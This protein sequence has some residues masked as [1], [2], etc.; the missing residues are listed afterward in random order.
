MGKGG[1][2]G[3]MMWVVV[4]WG[5]ILERMLISPPFNLSKNADQHQS[6][7]K[8]PWTS[9]SWQTSSVSLSVP[10]GV[11]EPLGV[12][13]REKRNPAVPWTALLPPGN[14]KDTK[15]PSQR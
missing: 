14:K 6:I 8:I 9:F 11:G 2:D 13:M 12:T 3:D 7:P 1:C 5:G 4:E 15:W 10:A